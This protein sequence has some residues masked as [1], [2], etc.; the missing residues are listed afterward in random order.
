MKVAFVG[1]GGSGKSS[2]S[3]LAVKTLEDMGE[4]ILAVDADHN[5]DLTSNLG[6]DYEKIPLMYKSDVA[7]GNTVGKSNDDTWVSI[8]SNPDIE[9]VKFTLSPIDSYT[10]Q[11]S[12]A[13]G[14]NLRLIVA[15]LGD[16]EVLYSGKCAHG[17]S[18][19]LK[20]YL[21]LFDDKNTWVVVDSV[22]GTDMVNFGLFAGLDAMVCVVEPHINSVKVYYQIKEIAR[23]TG[24]KLY[25]IINKPRDNELYRELSEKEKNLIIGELPFDDSITLYD[26]ST[27]KQGTKDLMK[28][29]IENIARLE[30]RK[31]L[32]S[33]SHFHKE[34]YQK[35]ASE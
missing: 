26:Y 8:L 4:N 16:P 32:D 9:K 30:K 7:F 18:N 33:L 22:A 19:P 27:L 20:Y 11:I 1:K 3:W 6:L 5:M 29:I 2:V 15:G 10:N 23:R 24:L 12:T 35:E 34:K 28:K 25:V 21:G 31:G 14:D 13:I 17:L